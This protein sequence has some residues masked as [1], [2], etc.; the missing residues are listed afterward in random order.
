MGLKFKNS[1]L[2][3]WYED[4]EITFTRGRSYKKND[5]CFV[6]QKNNSVV[7]YL[8]G[9]YR[10]EGQ[11]ALEAL[12]KPVEQGKRTDIISSTDSENPSRKGSKV[13][14]DYADGLSS[15]S[16]ISSEA[17]ESKEN[18]LNDNEREA[19][20]GLSADAKNVYQMVR[21]KLAGMKNKKVARAASAGAVLLARHA[22]IIARKVRA[23]LGTP[24]TAMDYYRTWFDLQYGGGKDADENVYAQRRAEMSDAERKEMQFRI[25]EETNPMHDDIHTGIR[26]VDDILTAK[27][28]FETKVDEDSYAYPDFTEA[29]GKAALKNGEA[30]IYSSYP[31]APGVFVTPSKMQAQDYAGGGKVYSKKVSVK[32]VAWIHSD[33]GQYAPIE[34]ESFNQSAWHGTPHDFDGFDLGAIGTGEG[35]QAHGWGLYFAQ[36]RNTSEGY[37]KRLATK[38]VTIHLGEKSYVREVNSYTAFKRTYKSYIR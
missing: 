28:A 32:D 26:S 38:S 12:E 17:E 34:T 10:Y 1:P 20:K 23:T 5:N 15:T 13:S 3:K 8:V 31:I 22:D 33:E 2:V 24:F 30:T 14:A 7:L 9:Y 16:T 25:I 21:D 36:E 4:N 6:E 27:E 19:V 35:G 18:R 29:D 11:Q 37:R